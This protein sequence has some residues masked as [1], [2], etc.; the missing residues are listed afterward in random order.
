MIIDDSHAFALDRLTAETFV[1]RVDYHHQVESTN[2]VG[3]KLCED[4]G[5]ETPVLVLTENQTAGRGRGSNQWWSTAGALTFSLVVDAEQIGLPQVLWPRASMTAGL[6]VCETLEQLLPGQE[7]GLKWPNDIHLNARKVCGILVEVGLKESNCLVVGIGLN[8]N[9]SLADA[10][11]PLKSMANSMFN[12][13]DRQHDLTDVLV[14]LLNQLE[15]K[16]SLLAN[17]DH[18]LASAWQKRCVLTGRTVQVDCGPN[19]IVGG[20]EGIDEDGALVL[21]TEAGIER[22]FGGVIT[23]IW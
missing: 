22:L 9:N 18:D 19:S 17:G 21:R 23:L 20:C 16:F 7:I 2:D 11:E 6:A 14:R 10:P 13:T 5:L 3:L 15:E 8:V 12:V 1:K 4:G